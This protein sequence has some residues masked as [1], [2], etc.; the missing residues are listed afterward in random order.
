MDS[1]AAH[2]ITS[3][4]NN[5]AL[6]QPYNGGDEVLLSD[7]SCLSITHSGSLSP[8]SLSRPINLTNVISVLD[9][10]KNL[11]SVYRLC[12]ANRVSVE[13]FSAHFQVKDLYT[14]IPLLQGQTKGDLYEWPTSNSV[15][16]SFFASS[17]PKSTLSSW[18]HRLGHP[19]LSIV[20]NI[21]SRFSLSCSDSRASHLFCSDCSRNKSHRLPFYASTVVSTRPLEIIF[22]DVWTSPI[23]SQDNYKYYLILVD[24][25]TRYSWLYPLKAKSDVKETFIRFKSLVE[26]RFKHKIGTFY[27]D[28]GGE[29]IAL[30]SFLDT[31]GIS[32]LT[33]PTHTPEHNR[34]S[35][36]KHCHVV[37]TGLTLLSH[38][39]VP[40]F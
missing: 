34:I 8:P 32:H 12:N 21:G 28:N 24:H 15:I 9:I 3:D 1:G 26:N 35:K 31:N 19:S 30:R 39:N 10:K 20:K 16:S 29:F 5:L 33:I 13:F 23:V 37:E 36:R 40:L 25:Y 7:N 6:H 38:A 2:H 18:H 22:S 17:Q 11:T 4:L 14:G 27:S